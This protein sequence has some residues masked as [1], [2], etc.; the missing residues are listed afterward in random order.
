MV[1]TVDEIVRLITPVAQKYNIPAVYLF[2]SYARAEATESSDVDLLIDTAG[3]SLTSLFK[4]AALFADLEDALH[5]PVD[6]ITVG[7]LMQTD[8]LPSDTDFRENVLKE[9][10]LL[11]AV[12]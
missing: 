11:Y 4:Q 8:I 5:K 1:Y 7:A 9:R 6:M 12:S 3:T 10:M 2:G